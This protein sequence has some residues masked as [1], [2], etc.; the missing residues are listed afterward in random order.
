SPRANG[1]AEQRPRAAGG[2]L[3]LRG[4]AD[5]LLVHSSAPFA[6]PPR[7]DDAEAIFLGWATDADVTRYLSWRPHQGIEDTTRFIA[8]CVDTWGDP[9]RRAWVITPFHGDKGIG[10]I[11][12]RVD[13]HRA[14]LGATYW[15]G[16][17][18]VTGT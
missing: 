12:L 13:G 5:G 10:M 15:H 11:E 8:G 4:R 17:R 2:I 16:Q 6:A 18:G 14:E 1:S 7:A 9:S 3:R